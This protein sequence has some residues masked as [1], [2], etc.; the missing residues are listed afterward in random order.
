MD[1][2][3]AVNHILARKDL[4][5]VKGGNNYCAK[6]KVQKKELSFPNMDY[7]PLS[8]GYKTIEKKQFSSYSDL[9][10]YLKAYK[11]KASYILHGRYAKSPETLKKAF[12]GD[13][14]LFVEK[15]RWLWNTNYRIE[16][17]ILPNGDGKITR[18][19]LEE[20]FKYSIRSCNAN[21]DFF[22]SFYYEMDEVYDYAQFKH[23]AAKYTILAQKY[24]SMLE[25]I[26]KIYTA[27]INK[28]SK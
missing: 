15:R 4:I 8:A 23:Y 20:Y 7:Q 18:A 19:E 17:S 3:K 26:D 9:Q 25:N 5:D 22:Y 2:D 27:Y 11:I 6:I 28:V 1:I 14:A 13:M 21:Y 10:E 16:V 24:K 12:Q